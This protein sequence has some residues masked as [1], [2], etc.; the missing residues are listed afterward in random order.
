MKRFIKGI[1]VGIGGVSPGLS[2]GVMMVIFDL[3]GQFVESIS[4]FF[5]NPK[6]SIKFLFPLVCGVG[7]GILLFGKIVSFL[8]SEQPMYTRFT[9]LGLVLGTLPLFYR[10][11]KK[12]G[13]K[14]KYYFIILGAFLIGFF[15]LSSGTLFSNVNNL[16]LFQKII[17]GLVVAASTIIPGIDSAVILSSIGLY[18]VYLNAVAELDLSVLIPAICGAVLGVLI[19]S[20]I[21][22][23]LIKR[24][25]TITYCVIF[26]LF[27]SI[28]PSV[29]DKG[30]KMGINFET[31]V[32][33]LLMIIGFVVSFYMGKRE[34]KD[35][36]FH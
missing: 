23:I 4:T 19:L 35:Q 15:L 10:E 34:A 3:Y 25:Y 16:N 5:K 20:M 32:S 22:N 27:I 12:K 17:L 36:S 13:F 29:L 28:I 11:V 2:G 1:L 8:L 18:E 9:F 6:K 30:F 21:M 33:I 31:I 26:G 14:N 7:L 24:Y